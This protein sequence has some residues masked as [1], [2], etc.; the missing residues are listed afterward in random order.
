MEHKPHDESDIIEH[1]EI[2]VSSEDREK[3][4]E[5]LPK[6]KKRSKGPF[7]FGAIVL[8]SFIAFVYM[9]PKQENASPAPSEQVA[10]DATSEPKPTGE[11]LALPPLG[12]GVPNGEEK[13]PVGETQ[14]SVPPVSKPVPKN[15]PQETA[16][17]AIPVVASEAKLPVLEASAPKSSQDKGKAEE[18]VK[19]EVKRE[20]R[21]GKT[22]ATILMK[23]TEVGE[24]SFSCTE[25]ERRVHKSARKPSYQ[26]PKRVIK[27]P[28]SKMKHHQPQQPKI[29]AHQQEKTVDNDGKYQR[30]F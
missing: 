1:E 27:Q 9:Q 10:E 22:G 14:A 21:T 2:E 30:L 7:V 13:T 8:V 20:E 28:A 6:K 25:T 18:G 19:Q 24:K 15:G 11:D 12:S 5:G 23:C 4:Y 17:A 16:R 3:K 29:V 26:V